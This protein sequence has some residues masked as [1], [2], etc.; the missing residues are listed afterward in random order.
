MAEISIGGLGTSFLPLFMNVLEGVFSE[1]QWLLW[2]SSRLRS[3]DHREEGCLNL[4]SLA[5]I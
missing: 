1:V 2:N 5:W 3:L 4:Y